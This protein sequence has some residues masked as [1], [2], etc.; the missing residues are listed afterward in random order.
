MTSPA[1]P[2]R[3][4]PPRRPAEPAGVA[5][6]NGRREPRRDRH[7]SASVTVSR[8]SVYYRAAQ[9]SVKSRNHWSMADIVA[10]F[11]VPAGPAILERATVRGCSVIAKL[12][13]GRSTSGPSTVRGVATRDRWW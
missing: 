5:I 7:P 4:P 9:S 12:V 2:V 6:V 8:M 13:R 3:T 10:S 11:A 1:P